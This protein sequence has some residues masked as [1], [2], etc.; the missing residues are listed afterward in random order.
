M[1]EELRRQ[2]RH[3]P[4]SCVH[5]DIPNV[6]ASSSSAFRA[7]CMETSV[8]QNTVLILAHNNLPDIRA[9]LSLWIFRDSFNQ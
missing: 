4:G 6:D 5:H 8:V 3:A 1:A 2:R 7:G 9:Y